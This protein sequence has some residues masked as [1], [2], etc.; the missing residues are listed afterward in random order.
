M[1]GDQNPQKRFQRI[2]QM[3]SSFEFSVDQYDLLYSW[4]FYSYLYEKL[5]NLLMIG[6]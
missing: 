4:W 3:L 2:L 1:M 6:L 5:G